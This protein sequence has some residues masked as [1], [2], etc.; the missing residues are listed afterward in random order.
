MQDELLK[1]VEFYDTL[2]IAKTKINNEE[3]AEL[4]RIKNKIQIQM[5]QGAK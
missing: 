3:I 1:L 2:I 4:E 5:L